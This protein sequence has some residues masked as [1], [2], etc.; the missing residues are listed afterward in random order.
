MTLLCRCK[1]HLANGI[2]KGFKWVIKFL[3]SK[4]SPNII[5]HINFF[6]TRKC[7]ELFFFLLWSQTVALG[8]S[9]WFL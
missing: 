8:C 3:K 9:V 4:I 2:Y 1:H 5:K 7:N 6:G